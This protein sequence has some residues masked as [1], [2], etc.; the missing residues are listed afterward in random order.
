MATVS[1]SQPWAYTLQLPRDAG[2]PKIARAVARETLRHYGMGELIETA[3]LLVSE[4]VTNAY[5]HSDGPS[6]LRIRR[7]EA[8]RLRIS[9]WD[10]NPVIPPPFAGPAQSELTVGLFGAPSTTAPYAEGGRGLL[11]VRLCAVNWGGYPLA[12]GL[13]GMAG[14]L[15]WVEVAATDTAFDIAA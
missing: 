13:F 10:T 4:L 12:E 2:A 15:L 6:S 11:L 14:K 8:D 9:V 7:M 3:E 1:P 5:L